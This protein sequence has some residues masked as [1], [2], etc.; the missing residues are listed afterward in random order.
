MRKN[1][2]RAAV[3]YV[4]VSTAG[5]GRSGLGLDAQKEAIASFCAA[6]G[7]KL[8]KTFVEVVSGRGGAD[9]LDSR[10]QLAAALK[11]ARQAE[12]PI[13]VSKLDRLSR[14]VH[15]VSGLMAHKVPFIVTELGSDVD[16]FVLHIF[17]ALAQKERALI[18]RRTREGL[19]QARARGVKLGGA[20]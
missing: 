13:I 14:D 11:A 20:N 9:T 4:R 5:Q 7:Y 3:A 8:G 10:P 12:G 19:A 16:P 17:A 1:V 2:P 15:F 18:S 6:E